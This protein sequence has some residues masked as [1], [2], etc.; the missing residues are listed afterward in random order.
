MREPCATI[1][2]SGAGQ[3]AI[4]PATTKSFEINLIDMDVSLRRQKAKGK[5][6]KA[7]S[8]RPGDVLPSALCLLPFRLELI[9]ERQ[10]ERPWRVA[11][12]PRQVE[13]VVQPI[14]AGVPLRVR[15]CVE[16]VEHAKAQVDRLTAELQRPREVQL[17]IAR[18]FVQELT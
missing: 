17:Q 2:S 15:A 5:R 1:G 13:R 12:E 18:R 14:R 3:I 16:H 6:Q 10:L 7:E 9:A 8:T 11:I 4:R